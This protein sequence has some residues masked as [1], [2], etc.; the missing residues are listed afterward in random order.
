[1]SASSEEGALLAGV[2]NFRDVARA[3]GGRLRAGRLFR[4]ATPSEAGHG[5]VMC[6]LN[7]FGVRT[8]VDFRDR[9]EAA[10]DPGRRLYTRFYPSDGE[11][12]GDGSDGEAGARAQLASHGDDGMRKARRVI[13]TPYATVRIGTQRQA[14]WTIYSPPAPFSGAL[15]IGV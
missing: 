6:L 11:S 15:R 14:R 12:S 5:A 9:A 4:S 3:A 10:A 2:G 8:I 13:R 7:T 1:M